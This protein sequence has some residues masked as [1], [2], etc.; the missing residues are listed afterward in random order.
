MRWVRRGGQCSP[1]PRVAMALVPKGGWPEMREYEVTAGDGP[2]RPLAPVLEALFEEV[3]EPYIVIRGG[4]NDPR[5]NIISDDV[6]NSNEVCFAMGADDSFLDLELFDTS[7]LP[8]EHSLGIL[9]VSFR[10]L[11]NKE[12]GVQQDT[13]S[14]L[15]LVVSF[16][17]EGNV[18][19]IAP[20][21]RSRG[22][23][24]DAREAKAADASQRLSL[25]SPATAPSIPERIDEVP[26]ENDQAVV[27]EPR[28]TG[29]DGSASPSRRC[30][31]FI[32]MVAGL[33]MAA[34]VILALFAARPPDG[35]RPHASA[36]PAPAPGAGAAALRQ[37][38]Q[39]LREQVHQEQAGASAARQANV[40]AYS[41]LR[42]AREAAAAAEERYRAHVDKLEAEL[43]RARAAAAA[44]ASSGSARNQTARPT[45]QP[46][47]T[48][49]APAATRGHGGLVALADVL[50]AQRLAAMLLGAAGLCSLLGPDA[51]ARVFIAGAG[52][53]SSSLLAAGCAGFFVFGASRR[54]A[55]F[56]DC[57]ADLLDGGAPLSGYFLWLLLMAAGVWRWVTGFSVV[58]CA[59]ADEVSHSELSRAQMA[60][61]AV[62]EVSRDQLEK[63]L[64]ERPGL[65][66]IRRTQHAPWLPRVDRH[67]DPDAEGQLVHIM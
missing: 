19:S 4:T 20:N 67:G 10:A 41:Q 11:D 43:R 16:Q 62:E 60:I 34:C 57:L 38:V 2:G 47:T 59:M 55:S 9:Q 27:S 42:Q 30:P 15:K 18:A 7:D 66:T 33:V 12:R 17:C 48:T 24:E 25:E 65:V 36:P 28:P 56:A 22:S 46:A 63:P 64:L 44:V 8:N 52:I 26:A 29:A 35:L 49:A 3:S 45:E 14:K 21:S 37:E 51:F 1:P 32:N 54:D 39:R 5:M 58:L 50:P 31:G 61:G 13:I 23:A 40:S 6:K 53:L